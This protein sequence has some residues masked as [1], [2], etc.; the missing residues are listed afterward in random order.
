[1]KMSVFAPSGIAAVRPAPTPAGR[2]VH[3][4]SGGPSCGFGLGLGFGMGPG[5]AGAPGS[6]AGA[7]GPAGPATPGGFGGGFLPHA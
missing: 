5:G 4:D 2:L 6:S 1:M 7:G 3:A